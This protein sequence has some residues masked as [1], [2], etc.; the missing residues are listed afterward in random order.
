MLQWIRQ[1]GYRIKVGEEG[2]GIREK[3]SK[4]ARDHPEELQALFLEVLVKGSWELVK[5]E[6]LVNI[7]PIGLAPKPSKI[8]PFRLINDARLVNE[9]VKGRKF[10]YESLNAIPLVVKQGDFMF[11]LDLEDAYYSFLLQ[12]ESRNLFGGKL[13]FSEQMQAR[14]KEEGLD[15]SKLKGDTAFVRPKGLPMGFKNSCAIWT[16]IFRTLTRKWREQGIPLIHYMDDL[17]F[18]A[19]SQEECD[20]IRSIVLN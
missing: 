15:V 18:S 16:K 9:H 20:R 11:T 1:G 4:E 6:E 7:I 2:M 14:L 10:R 19:P 13:E 17:L 12:E 3:N 8:P 5:E